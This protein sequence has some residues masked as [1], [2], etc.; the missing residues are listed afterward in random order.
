MKNYFIKGIIMFVV[1]LIFTLSFILRAQWTFM[2]PEY[3]DAIGVILSI[4][5]LYLGI[6]YLIAWYVE[7]KC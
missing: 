5:L 2:I 1:G 6:I 4:L 7:E 3:L